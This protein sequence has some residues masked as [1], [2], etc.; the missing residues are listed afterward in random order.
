MKQKLI[1]IKK[2]KLWF[3]FILYF[4][5]PIYNFFWEYIINFHGKI[6]YFLWFTK[7]RNFFNIEFGNKLILNDE[8]VLTDLANKILKN[9]EEK[10]LIQVSRDQIEKNQL[11]DSYNKA[12]AGDNAYIND[13]FSYLDENIKDQIISFAS[14]DLMISTAARYIKVFPVLAKVLCYHNIPKNSNLTRGAMLWHKD[15]FGYKSLD[16]FLAI[17]NITDE[18][19]PL[20]ALENKDDLGVFRKSLFY[21]RNAEPGERNKINI[22]DF[23][24]EKNKEIYL[25]GK[26]GSAMLID[27]F[28]DFHRGGHCISGDRVMLRLSYQTVD[29]TRF[30]ESKDLFIYYDKIKKKDI[31]SVFLKYLFFKNKNFFIKNFLAYF[32]IRF[33]KIF[34]YKTDRF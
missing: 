2:T 8:K 19:G 23:F 33:Y 17:T 12:N 32:L 22:E 20:I 15:D 16:I 14:S 5:K 29:C 30:Q 24:L 7:K 31:K 10:N 25:L 34:S 1:Y 4:V 13:I 3:Y 9:I 18:N 6:L 11:L 27:S 26:P 21:V 28:S